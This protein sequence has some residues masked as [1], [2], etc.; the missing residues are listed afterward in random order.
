VTEGSAVLDGDDSLIAFDI[1]LTGA[2]HSGANN[3]ITGIDLSL[4]TPDADATEVAIVLDTDWDVGIDMDAS[5]LDLDSDGDTSICADTEDTIDIEINAADDF[6]FTANTFTILAGSK[7]NSANVVTGTH[8][9]MFVCSGSHTHAST[10]AAV[11]VCSI[12]ANANVVD[13]IYTVDTQWNDGAS[14]AVNCGI[15]GGDV[16]AFV[17]AM[18]INDGADFN[19][20]GDNG[21]MP[22]ATSLIDVGAS[23]VDVICQVA[24]GNDDASAG[25]ATLYIWYI[26]D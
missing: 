16:D 15:E 26:I 9:V 24:E 19:R 12:P 23:D 20:M 22:Y 1:N 21:D 13:V 14:A 25:A 18:N 8:G 10:E 7:V 3:T 11:D 6:Q 4:T 2:D 5:C 17:A